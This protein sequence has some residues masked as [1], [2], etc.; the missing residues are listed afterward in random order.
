MTLDPHPVRCLDEWHD[1]TIAPITRDTSTTCTCD[2]PFALIRGLLDCAGSA[3]VR[4]PSLLSSCAD[5]TRCLN[6]SAGQTARNAGLIR[7][8]A[9]SLC[10]FGGRVWW[11]EPWSSYQGRL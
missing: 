6:R 8:S 7:R 4:V 3:K 5:P 1:V 9:R 10:A 11:Q 2:S